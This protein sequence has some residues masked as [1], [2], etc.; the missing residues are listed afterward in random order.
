MRA[1]PSGWP[2]LSKALRIG[3]GLVALWTAWLAL[4]NL[5]EG[6]QERYLADRGAIAIDYRE[7]APAATTRE[8]F[9]GADGKPDIA[10]SRDSALGIGVRTTLAY[11]SRKAKGE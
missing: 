7:T 6:E 1:G 9:L 4:A 10:K 2:H 5:T 11:L 8:I 3:L